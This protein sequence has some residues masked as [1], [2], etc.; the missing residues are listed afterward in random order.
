MAQ[1]RIT[2]FDGIVARLIMNL[3]DEQDFCYGIDDQDKEESFIVMESKQT[4][5]DLQ[6]LLKRIFKKTQFNIKTIKK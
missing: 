6:T 2:P 4:I 3:L 5:D 1:I